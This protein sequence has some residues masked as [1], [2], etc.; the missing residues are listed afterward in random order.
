MSS[1][2]TPSSPTTA[3][4]A[5]PANELQIENFG[6]AAVI[7]ILGNTIVEANYRRL[8]ELAKAI[9]LNP[10]AGF[11]ELVPAYNSLLV[12]FDP[13]LSTTDTMRAAVWKLAATMDSVV[14]DTTKDILELPVAYGGEYGPDLEEVANHAGL[15]VE[16]AIR[17][18]SSSP[19]L[20]YM[21]GF[22]PGFPYLGGLDPRIATPRLK[23]PRTKVPAGS[24]G[25][26]DTQTGVYPLESPGGWNLIGRTPLALFDPGRETPALLAPGKYVRF[27]PISQ[28][29]FRQLHQVKV[30][31]EPVKDSVQVSDPGSKQLSSRSIVILKPGSLSTVQDAGRFGYQASGVPPSGPMDEFCMSLANILAGNEAGA[32]CIECTLGGLE[33]RFD[34]DCVFALAGADTPIFLNDQSV[35]MHVTLKAQA[36]E[37]GRASCRERV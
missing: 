26:A 36:G 35:S 3:Q 9:T 30:N 23:T 13:L 34:T 10:P 29:S 21:L 5:S 8:A 37:I 17:I 32:A 14:S 12:V 31:R 4:P 15:S 6:E 11:S 18:H 22:T 1:S 28:D 27:V 16:E 20:V 7:V 24:V 33:L 19:Y 25:I 2:T